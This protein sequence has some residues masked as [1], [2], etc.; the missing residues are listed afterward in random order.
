MARFILDPVRPTP[1][2]A[3]NPLAILAL[4]KNRK[5]IKKR[6][7]VPPPPPPP[8]PLVFQLLRG[9]LYDEEGEVPVRGDE[10]LVLATAHAEVLQHVGR[11]EG[12][13]DGA[14]RPDQAGD[15][16]GVLEGG[17]IR[18]RT[19]RIIRTLSPG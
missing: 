2:P 15:Q 14:G 9:R 16:V 19:R 6:N 11:V 18:I 10:D 7:D 3:L 12:A 1:A 4:A 13:D 8:L 5:E 17:R